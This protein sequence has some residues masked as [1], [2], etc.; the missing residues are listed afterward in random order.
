TGNKLAGNYRFA[1]ASRG[2][3]ALGHNSVLVED[4][5]Y[6]VVYHTRYQSG[7]TGVTGNHNQFVNQLF[8]NNDGWP[9]MAPNRY[10][11][12]SAGRVDAADAAGDYDVV[13]H[14]AVGNSVTFAT[15]SLYT[16]GA[17][18]NVR[19]SNTVRGNWERIGEYHFIVTINSVA[20]NGVIV[21]QYDNDMSRACLSFTGVSPAGVSMWANKRPGTTSI[22]ESERTVP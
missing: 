14:T 16:F 18:G 5:K 21:P 4:G 10:A 12:E 7:T 1:N 15:S 13:I 20:Y 2:Y 19:Q 22:T 9:V 3:A 6:Y 8:F 17:D 11:G